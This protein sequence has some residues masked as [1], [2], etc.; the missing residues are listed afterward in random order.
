MRRIGAVILDDLTTPTNLDNKTELSLFEVGSFTNYQRL[1]K[2]WRTLFFALSKPRVIQVTGLCGL[3]KLDQ[4]RLDKAK[5]EHSRSWSPAVYRGHKN[6]ENVESLG[7]LVID[8]DN[9]DTRWPITTIEAAKTVWPGV[10][11]FI[12]TSFHHG[13]EKPKFRLVIP[14]KRR[15][16]RAEHDVIYRYADG[17]H[18]AAG[19]KIDDSC[20]NADRL[21]YFGTYRPEHFFSELV[22]GEFFDPDSILAVASVVEAITLDDH[23]P[24]RTEAQRKA[25]GPNSAWGLSALRD[26]VDLLVSAQPGTGHKTLTRVAYK[27]GQIAA[28]GELD[29][30]HALRE[31]ETGIAGWD[32][33]HAK[34][35]KTLHTCFENGKRAPRAPR[36]QPR[37]VPRD[38]VTPFGA[39]TG[40]AGWAHATPAKADDPWPEPEPLRERREVLPEFPIDALPPVLAQWVTAISIARQT[41][42]GMAA[43][44]TLGTLAI[45]L[46]R[47][48]RVEIRQGWTE[49]LSLYVAVVLPPGERKS[50]I[51]S[52]CS[53]PIVRWERQQAEEFEQLIA[54]AQAEA[55][56]LKSRA[57]AA[58]KQAA[59]DDAGETDHGDMLAAGRM[60]RDAARKIPVAPQLIANDTTQEAL[61][62]KMSK[63]HDAMGIYDS[64]GIGPVSLMLGRYNDGAVSMEL[65]LKGHDGG[66][67]RVGRISRE[68]VTLWCPRISICL[69]M[70]PEVLHTMMAKREFRGHGLLA[71]FLWCIP[72]PMAGYRIARAPTVP[73]AVSDAY[74]QLIHRLLDDMMRKEPN[75]ELTTLVCSP[76]ADDV[77]AR[78]HSEIEPRMLHG[79]DLLSMKDWSSKYLGAIAR[80]AGLLHAAEHP[81]Q[82]EV[83]S[84]TGATMENAARIG[85]YCL[86]QAQYIFGG[87]ADHD[88]AVWQAEE[89]LDYL[90]KHNITSFQK[91]DL[92]QKLRTKF[93]RGRDARANVA[94]FD[95]VLDLLSDRG[96]IRLAEADRKEGAGRKTSPVFAVHE[97]VHRAS[98]SLTPERV[99]QIE[100]MTDGEV[101]AIGEA[102]SEQELAALVTALE[103]TKGTNKEEATCLN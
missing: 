15:V 69:A 103:A 95:A 49:V 61:G 76:E 89:V 85:Q 44:F 77:I 36:D 99:A 62:L 59:R 65:Y 22:E 74:D 43:M 16:T 102:M 55:D 68:E 78:V 101:D 35:L 4:A 67:V 24:A 64:E 58:K 27:T 37:R 90:K 12:H 30:D 100:A 32:V 7:A 83:C 41:P 8:V 1:E 71:R 96:W 60:A 23:R 66:F 3:P 38:V 86:A 25:E 94:D 52:D 80:I 79:Q 29:D 48:H 75:E 46:Q 47:H 17:V 20:K 92:H 57:E 50:G 42:R 33:D 81:D 53:G 13:P 14:Y 84:I 63:Q 56:I 88:P 6:L 10:C 54:D 34:Y 51:V 91:R 18:R 19:Q 97:A 73:A 11:L 39:G 9:K 28:G 2:S 93:G 5:D 21:W 70:Q 82:P 40:D 31:L 72:A 26:H 87:G 45:I 98:P